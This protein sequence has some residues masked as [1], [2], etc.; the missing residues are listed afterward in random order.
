MVAVIGAGSWGTTLA[1]VAA[2]KGEK[3]R[4]WARNP[5]V[6][7]YMQAEGHNPRYVPDLNFPDSL[8]PTADLKEG[9]AGEDVVIHAVPSHA[10]R[11]TARLYAKHLAPE[12]TIVSATKGLE[13]PSHKRMSQVIAEETGH[14]VAALTGP[15]HA[16]EVSVGQPTAAV[17]AHP[18]VYEAT[19][20]ADLLT[21]PTFKVYPRRDLVGVELCGAYKNVAALAAGM[22]DGLGWGDNCVACI[23]T[24]G[25]DEM[26]DVVRAMGGDPR[27][28]H[29]LAGVGDLVA[30]AT[31]K[32]SRNRF[33]GRE[34]ARGVPTDLIKRKMH[35]MVAEGVH[36]TKA[37][38]QYAEDADLALPLTRVV[39]SVVYHGVSVMDGVKDLLSRV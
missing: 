34:L 37:F 12:A 31:S 29:G 11:E 6:V 19:S 22:A 27:T 8:K 32:H 23:V 10:T 39:H 20:L 33:Y 28:P 26:V 13:T 15:N 5:N 30:T 36:A 35:G 1:A 38:Y 4:L 21:T 17:L 9:L 18:E 14:P 25:V 24:L 16:E 2:G 7:S 3:V